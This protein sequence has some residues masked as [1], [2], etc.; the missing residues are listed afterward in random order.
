[1]NI[2]RVCFTQLYMLSLAIIS[3]L[4]KEYVNVASL[5]MSLRA[6][7]AIF[8]IGLLSCGIYLTYCVI[9]LPKLNSPSQ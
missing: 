2:K 3:I 4:F 5:T 9:R 6:I 8:A 1:M 7:M